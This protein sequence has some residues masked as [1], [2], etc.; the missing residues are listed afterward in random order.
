MSRKKQL[1]LGLAGLVSIC[2][3]ISLLSTVTALVAALQAGA[4]LP[5]GMVFLTALTA[6]CTVM[7]WKGVREMEE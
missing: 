2:F 3:L 1:C 5:V 7:L 6:M 4:E